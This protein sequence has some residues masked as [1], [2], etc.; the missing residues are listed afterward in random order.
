MQTTFGFEIRRKALHI[1]TAAILA[2][3]L[4]Y[5]PYSRI[6]LTQL[7]VLGIMLSLL[8]KRFFLPGITPLLALFEREEEKQFPGKPLIM[9]LAGALATEIF[10]GWYLA[11]IGLLILAFADSAAHLI[12]KRFG[13][14]AIPW[15]AS[16]HV[17]GR[18]A[19]AA[20]S[21]LI[22]SSTVTLPLLSLGLISI[23]IMVIES[24]PLKKIG[25]DDNLLIPIITALLTYSFA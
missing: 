8:Q 4:V 13:R 12:G 14:I 25:L 2:L 19:G 5:S 10:F 1:I 22:L 16:R 23:L 9:M 20:V 6:L 21:F 11:A 24:L 7:L 18:I 3:L 17:E 15:D